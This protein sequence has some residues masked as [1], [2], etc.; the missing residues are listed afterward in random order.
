MFLFF[1][2]NKKKKEKK[3][4]ISRNVGTTLIERQT[5]ELKLCWACNKTTM[6]RIISIKKKKHTRKSVGH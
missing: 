4:K 2:R 6:S 1:T 5:Q 3:Y